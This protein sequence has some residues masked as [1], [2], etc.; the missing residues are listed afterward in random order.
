MPLPALDPEFFERWRT[1]SQGVE[2]KLY[3]HADFLAKSHCKQVHRIC[4]IYM[5]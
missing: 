2:Y 5:S 3:S 4:A 1:D